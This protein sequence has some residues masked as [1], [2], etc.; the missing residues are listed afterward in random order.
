[1]DI[2]IGLLLPINVWPK[3]QKSSTI[4]L[5]YGVLGLAVD[6]NIWEYKITL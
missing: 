3:Y 4:S 2:V 5:L 1:M 6:F